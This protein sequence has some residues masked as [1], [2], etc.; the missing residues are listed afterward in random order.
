MDSSSPADGSLCSIEEL[1]E[2]CPHLLDWDFG[3]LGDLFCEDEVPV[4]QIEEEKRG[5]I[6]VACKP[7]LTEEELE[8]QRQSAAV[9]C[10][11][12]A[13]KYPRRKIV[14]QY[15]AQT[16]SKNNITVSVFPTSSNK[17]IAEVKLQTTPGEFP[18]PVFY[19]C[20]TGKRVDAKEFPFPRHF[21][22]REII[23][24]PDIPL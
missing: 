8:A 7:L 21:G 3:D 23:G 20:D 17:L 10:G 4:D 19:D 22:I 2:K 16:A 11:M 24:L 9:A 1:L 12:D 14:N 15:D 6:A 13:K 18:S 5:I